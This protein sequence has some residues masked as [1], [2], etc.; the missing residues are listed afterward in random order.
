MTINNLRKVEKSGIIATGNVE[1][2][3]VYI[4]DIKIKR[5]QNGLFFEMP[6]RNYQDAEGNWKTAYYAVP[7]SKESRDAILA[8]IQTLVDE[9]KYRAF[10][11]DKDKLLI[12]FCSVKVETPVS[13]KVMLTEKDGVKR[14]TTDYRTYEKDGEKKYVHYVGLTKEIADEIL[15]EFEKL[16]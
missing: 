12:G 4:N 10:T 1:V 7:V 15:V 6:G 5:G 3:D 16:V 13:A 14:V 2:K 11:S 9:N 8:Q